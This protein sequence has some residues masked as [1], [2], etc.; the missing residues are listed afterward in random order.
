LATK[1]SLET[2][3]NML[4]AQSESFQKFE[5]ELL[6]SISSNTWQMKIE[7][8]LITVVITIAVRPAPVAMLLDGAAVEPSSP[9]PDPSREKWREEEKRAQDPL[10]C[11]LSSCMTPTV[12][13]SPAPTHSTPQPRPKPPSTRARSPCPVLLEAHR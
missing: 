12:L 1:I 7:Q 8:I 4:T 11:L 2:L 9:Y 3:T 10:L 13:L 5:F 6:A